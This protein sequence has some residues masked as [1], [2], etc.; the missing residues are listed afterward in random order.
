MTSP[1][2]SYIVIVE[3]PYSGDIERNLAYAR[4][5][6]RDCFDRGEVPYASH[7]L[8]TQEGVLD[9][10]IGAERLRG[11]QAGYFFWSSA[12]KIVF[13]IDL[14]WSTGMR[15][16]WNRA[17]ATGMDVEE[18]WLGSPWSRSLPSI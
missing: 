15:A 9:D 3:S 1:Q 12:R 10:N 14:G 11:I 13:Y 16:A 8:Y 5:C 17:A 18:R 6:L 2:L 7:L 4:A